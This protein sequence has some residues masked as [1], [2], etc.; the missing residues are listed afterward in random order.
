MARETSRDRRERVAQMQA[1]Q[2]RAE[3]RRLLVVIV[4]CVAVIAIIGAAVAWAVIGE[5]NKKNEA[6]QSISGDV[7]AASCD[8]VTDDPASGSSE[9]VGP[10]TKQANVTKIEYSTVPPSSGK[11]F[12]V[13]AVDKRRV[14]TVADAPQIETLVHNLEHGYTILWYDRSLEKEQAATFEALAT[15]INAMKESANKFLVS[16]WDPAYGAFPAGKKYALSHWSADVDQASGKVSNQLGHRQLCGGLNTT[17]VEDFVK[18]YPW[19]SAPEPG[20]A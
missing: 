12:A 1:A 5:Q 13:P 9:H 8:P 15:K 10:G 2:K 18:K 6:L 16:P 20:A 7:A 17:V 19:S 3:R 14:Y 4:A 11:H